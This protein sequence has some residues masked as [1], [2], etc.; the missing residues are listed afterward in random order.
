MID[1]DVRK[2]TD[3]KEYTLTVASRSYRSSYIVWQ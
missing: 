3:Y 1:R 2:V